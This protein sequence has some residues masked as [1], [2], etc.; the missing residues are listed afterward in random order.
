ML[1]L[2]QDKMGLQDCTIAIIGQTLPV[3]IMEQKASSIIQILLGLVQQ[4]CPVLQLLDFTVSN[5]EFRS[6]I[7]D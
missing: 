7:L 6:I 5:S 2:A 3:L 1:G 4:A